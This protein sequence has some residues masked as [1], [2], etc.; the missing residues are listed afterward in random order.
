M[1]NASIVP[2]IV[3]HVLP[4][5]LA[6]IAQVLFCFIKFG[7][8]LLVLMLLILRPQPENVKVKEDLFD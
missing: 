4:Q 5:L 8:Q 6:M 2:R 3:M 1:K 7:A